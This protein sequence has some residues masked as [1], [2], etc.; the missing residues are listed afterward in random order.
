[1]KKIWYILFTAVFFL[2]CLVPSVGMAIFGPAPAVANEIPVSRPQLTNFDG[3]FNTGVLEQL[4]SYIGSG[5]FLRLEGITA[6]DRLCA[7]GFATSAN[8]DVLIGPDGWLFYGG[9]VN[10]ISGAGQMTDRQ[11]WCAARGL[12]LMQEYAQ[13][14]GA[15]LLFTAV[16]GKYTLY[17]EHAPKYVTVAEGSNRER[18]EDAL[19]EQDVNYVNLYD[20]FVQ[21]DE[22]LYWQWDSH[23]NSR[24]AALA[25]DAIMAAAGE[26]T[27]YFA[28]PFTPVLDHK[29]DLYEML[30]PTGTAL[31]ADYTWEPGFTFGYLSNFRSADDISIETENPGVPGSLLMFRDS[32]GR[33]LYP[34]MAQSFGRAYFSRETN[35]RLDY[36]NQQL[37]TLVVI[38]I[39]E[40]TLPYLL[41][42]PA[43]YPAP[44]RDAGVL[45]DARPVDSTLTA[46]DADA[47]MEGYRR[48]GGTL[49]ETA[50]DEA[51]YLAVDMAVYEAIPDEGS[52]TAYIPADA[53]W[54]SAQI[55]VGA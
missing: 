2:A 5:F 55:Y 30:Y 7:K 49:P 19:E 45:A 3:S 34:Y 10:D 21:Q 20:P 1:M 38:E 36:V 44:A 16:C 35:Y 22:E 40:R 12:A 37:A 26:D 15:D 54:Q 47:A 27:D 53:D 23:W 42:Y 13:S 50:A 29:G 33:S 39:A 52:F 46:D 8:D 11:I 28:G 9:A 25:A 41:K 24:G 43:V 14:Q 6:W 51:V 17:P 32:S 48:L 4:Q 18:L 31:E